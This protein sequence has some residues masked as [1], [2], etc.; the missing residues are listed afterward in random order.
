M[1][2]ESSEDEIE[3]TGGEKQSKQSRDGEFVTL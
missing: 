3:K 2:I 1:S